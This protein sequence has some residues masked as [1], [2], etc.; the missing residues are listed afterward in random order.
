MQTLRQDI[1]YA[2][3]NLK[4]SPG[5]AI[6]AMLTLALGIGSSTAI[7]SVLE[8]ILLEP[9]PYPDAQRFM[10]VQIHDTDR[11]EPGGRGEYAGPEFLDL[12]EQSHSFDR[13]VANANLDV[14]YRAS[15]GTQ[16]FKGN[17]V[18]PGTFEF[19]GM[20]AL[21]GRVMQPADYEPGAPPVFVLRYKT[22]IAQFAGDPNVLNR[23]FVLNGTSRTLIG[24]M[25]P[26]F[27][28]GDAELWIPEKANRQADTGAYAGAFPIY[29]FFMGHLKPG[30]T[31]KEAEA[32]MTVVAKRL[33]AVYPKQA[34]K[35]GCRAPRNMGHRSYRR[36]HF[37]GYAR[38]LHLAV[39]LRRPAFWVF[40][41]EH[42]R[43]DRPDSGDRRRI[44][45]AGL[46][47]RAPHAR[48][49][50]SHGARSARL[51]C[52]G[53]GHPHG[54][55]AGRHRRSARSGGQLGH[56]PRHRHAALGRLCLR[57]L[58]AELCAAGLVG[59]G[60]SG[61]LAARAARL[62]C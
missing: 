1:R 34:I 42:L 17:L 4:K 43:L 44:Q 22:W 26:R 3:R 40:A 32:D 49:W 36:D 13:V 39:F 48:D 6:V 9:F 29:W 38:K 58:D 14:L 10:S 51:G 18:T 53:H 28:W 56:W 55:H 54:P 2:F 21:V 52:A 47:H 5:F 61:V 20:P 62:P 60:L 19:F 41:D 45:R 12:V 31:V 16:L 37:D 46:Y 59:H 27:A 11:S 33:A 24:V 7:F 30:V 15:E 23:N 50:H 25:P 57:P 8:N 35:P